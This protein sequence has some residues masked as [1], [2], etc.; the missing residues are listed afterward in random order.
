[1]NLDAATLWTATRSDGHLKKLRDR[2]ITKKMLNGEP[3][4]AAWD[5]IAEYYEKHGT[6]PSAG[7][8]AEQTGAQVAA[9]AEE[10]KVAEGFLIDMLYERAEFRALNYGM[11][12][13]EKALENGDQKEAVGEV[14]RLADHLRQKRADQ[15]HIHSLGDV[16]PEVLDLYERVKR[17]ETGIPFP[18][19][20]MTEMTLGMWPGTLTFFVAR[21][22]VGKTW[23]AVILALH[24]WKEAK[25]RVLIVSPEMGRVELGER[26]V[27]KYG[28]FAYKDMVSAT[29]GDF[30]ERRLREVVKELQEAGDGLFI[31]DNEEKLEP[32]YIEQAIESV[33]PEFVVFDSLYMLKVWKGKVKSGPG[34]RGDRHERV[35]DTIDWMRGLSRRSWSFAPDGLPCVGIHQLSREG[36]VKKEAARSLKAGRGTGGL[37]DAVALS[38][39]LFWNAHNLFA[40]YQDQYMRQDKQLLYAPLKA[41]RQAKMCSLVIKWDMESM[42]FDEI[43]TRVVE[44]DEFSDDDAGQVPY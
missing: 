38:D 23:T 29:L 14:I 1:M 12:K 28:S 7:I 42:E 5:F 21:P 43:G 2:G 19:Q 27:S 37:E 40:M 24:A 17:G 16:A 31:L 20:T 35:N 22:G 33:Q 8:V 36:K 26:M 15:L 6:V 3:A 4:Q 11:S 18:W 32:S 30:G 39:A 25:K 9:P 44:Q 34:S 13:A 10:D 41:R